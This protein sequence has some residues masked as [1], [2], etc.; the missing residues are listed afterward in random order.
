MKIKKTE[1]RV[2]M[3]KLNYLVALL[4]LSLVGCMQESNITEPVNHTDKNA[5]TIIML[6]AQADMNIESSFSASNDISGAAGG[7]IHLVKSYQAITGQTVTVDCKLTVPPN[8]YSF[9]DIRNITMEVGNGAEVDFYPSM[10]FN[11]PVIL[12]FTVS[13]LDLSGVD[14]NDVGF[15]YVANDGSLTPTANEGVSVDVNSGTLQVFNAKL[16]HFSRW[17]YAR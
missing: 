17:A 7:E 6:P 13:G 12:N 16:P 5:K 1:G 11:Q 15:F 2:K 4:L 3:Q 9:S 10:T 14:A 8:N